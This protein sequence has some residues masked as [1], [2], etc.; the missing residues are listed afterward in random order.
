[1]GLVEAHAVDEFGLRKWPWPSPKKIQAAAL[2]CRGLRGLGPLGHLGGEDVEVAVAVDVG[3]L[4]AVAVDHVAVHEIVA[5]PGL[6]V[7]RIA[8]ALVPPQRPDAVAGGDDDLRVF[9]G[10]NCPA[11]IRPPMGPI[12]TGGNFPPPAYLNQ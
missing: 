2:D 4:Q 5:G 10:L 11:R 9:P 7:R 3:D 8:A 12:W 6:G 1:M